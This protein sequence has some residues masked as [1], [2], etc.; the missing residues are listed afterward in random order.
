MRRITLLLITL[1]SLLYS[2]DIEKLLAE[3]DKSWVGVK[4][5]TAFFSKKEL[6]NGRIYEEKN[7]LLKQAKPLK[8]YMK[9]T[10]GDDEGQEIIYH[11][12]KYGKKLQAHGG[13]WLNVVNVSLDPEGSQAM[14]KSRHAVY[15]SGIG[16]IHELIKKN[17]QLTKTTGKGKI[18]FVKEEMFDNKKTYLFQADLP[19]NLGFYAKKILV[20]LDAATKLPLRITVYGFKN[21]FL[22]YYAF[23]NLK[24][25][26][27]LTDKDF[28][29][30]H[31]DYKF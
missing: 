6:L 14:K 12:E 28:D 4:D 24:L 3:A 7:V 16:H 18:A 11:P 17:Y 20:N 25:N 30:D 29:M 26:P 21:E 5:F 10:Q 1:S 15:D 2:Q 9:W 19:E 13:G 27:G 8:V 31:R 23:T 22:E